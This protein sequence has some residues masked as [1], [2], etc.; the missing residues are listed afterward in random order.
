MHPDHITDLD[1]GAQVIVY[2]VVGG[3]SDLG[4]P[5]L[6][7]IHRLSTACAWI[8]SNLIRD[9]LRVVRSTGRGSAFG[10]SYVVRRST[11]EAIE[12]IRRRDALERLHAA[13]IM[14]ADAIKPPS[15]PARAFAATSTDDLEE[16]DRRI[17]AALLPVSRSPTT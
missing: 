16:L 11:P 14:V 1:V 9:S 12:Q 3:G 2:P 17:R 4:R 8:R 15:G 10:E 7:R 6:G 5:A 13:L